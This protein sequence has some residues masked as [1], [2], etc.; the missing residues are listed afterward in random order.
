M[1]LRLNAEVQHVDSQNVEKY[2]LKST[3]SSDSPRRGKVPP[4]GI[5]WCSARL[6]YIRLG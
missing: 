1:A 3:D 5:R 6:G 2:V 4:A